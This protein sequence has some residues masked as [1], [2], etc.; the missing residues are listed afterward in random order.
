MVAPF[1]SL[2]LCPVT[3]GRAAHLKSIEQALRQT[4]DGQGQTLIIAGEAGIGKSRLIAE[5][6]ARAEKLGF[7]VLE[8]HC[9]EPDRSLPYAP[10]LD[11]LRARFGGRSAGEITR[12]LGSQAPE[13]ARLLPELATLLASNAPRVPLEPDQEKHRLIQALIQ[14]VTARATSQPTLVIVEDLHWSDDSSLDCLLYLARRIAA[15]PIFVLLTYRTDQPHPGLRHFLAEL[16]RGRLA[17]ELLLTPLDTVEVD[18]MLRAIFALNRPVRADFL[19]PIASLTEGNPFFVEEVLKSLVAAGDV[20]Y[21]DDGWDR[22]PVNE[23]RIPRTVGDAVQRRVEQLTGGAR[24]TLVLAAVAGHRFDFALLQ[25]L[26][27]RDERELLRQVKELIAA[28]LIVEESAEQFA[29]R[30]ALTRQAVYVSLLVRERRDLHRQVA[31]TMERL[32]AAN[33]DVHRNELAYHFYEAGEWTKALESARRAG[34]RAQA[35]DAPR[36]AV[37]HFTRAIDAARALSLEPEPSLHRARGLAYEVIGEFERARADLERALESACTIGDRR[38]E[39]QALLDLGFLWASRDYVRTGDYFHRALN[40]AR[41]LD[42]PSLIARSLNRVGNWCFNVD[43]PLEALQYHKDALTTFEALGDRHGIAETADLLGLVTGHIGAIRETREH[44]ARAIALFRELGDR[45]G[46][47][48]TLAQKADLGASHDTDGPPSSEADFAVGISQAEEAV[49]IAREIGWRAG[50]AF[51]LAT[52]V[53]YFFARGAFEQA[54]GAARRSLAIAEEIEHHQWMIV[55][56][57]GLGILYSD[58]LAPQVGR[59][60]L[61]WAAARAREINS[62][63]WVH[64][65]TGVLASICLQ[66]GDLAQAAE[67]LDDTMEP[68]TP[69][70][71]WA[72]RVSWLARAE[73]ALTHGD[74]KAALA[75]VERLDGTIFSLLDKSMLERRW[76]LRGQALAALNRAVE[77]EDA[78]LSGLQVL[79]RSGLRPLLWRMHAALG[80]FYQDQKRHAEAEREFLAARTIV[81]ELAAN[82][83]DEPIPELDQSSLREHFLQA[84]VS[85][86]PRPRPLTPLRAA[87]QKF[88]G[89]TAREREVAALIARGKSNHEIAETLFVGRRT[90]QTHIGNIFAKLGCTSRVQV[91]AWAVAHGLA[92]DGD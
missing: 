61:E 63:Y 20:F 15:Q 31:E 14:Y 34:E 73:L 10:F 90:V 12:E 77:A 3:I 49:K 22:K 9:L 18:A 72:Q 75:I 85:A 55:A 33:L 69:T 17:T 81:E 46:L 25:A 39:W 7:L 88:G 71:T 82:V 92:D 44:Y 37:E 87:K 79:A 29:F 65:M 67:L 2:V 84:A 51:G 64:C 21:T 40:L 45:R 27:Q 60:H 54:F 62:R 8:G 4:V 86:I 52:L 26:T 68:N 42:E 78:F 80:K 83:P 38:G 19:H 74:P 47:A 50:E 11:L 5:A 23:L 43:R 89:L 66:Q 41:V 57:G 1:G 32:Y 35:M 16:D 53:L 70:R 13:I 36:A 24:E 91:A 30:H 76:L 58:L 56:R 48:S 28:Q 59:T 6:K